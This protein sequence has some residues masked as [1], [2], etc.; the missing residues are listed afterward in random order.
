MDRYEIHFN[1]RTG[2]C[3]DVVFCV[4]LIGTNTEPLDISPARAAAHKLGAT[5]V[6][7]EVRDIHEV[8]DALREL[9]GVVHGMD[10]VK[11][12]VALPVY[13]AAR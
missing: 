9:H 2:N 5:F 8:I 13:F 4:T 10:V 7:E 12:G 11:A 6:L 1:S 3:T